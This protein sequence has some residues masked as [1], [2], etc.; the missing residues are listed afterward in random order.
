MAQRTEGSVQ[1][2]ES[3]CA[4]HSD[5]SQRVG[6]LPPSPDSPSLLHSR[7]VGTFDSSIEEWELE[8]ATRAH[9][10][11]RDNAAKHVRDVGNKRRRFGTIPVRLRGRP[12]S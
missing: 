9:F 6:H 3:W 1:P 5:Q 4:Q 12:D 8:K 2:W 7:Q 11:L 10:Q